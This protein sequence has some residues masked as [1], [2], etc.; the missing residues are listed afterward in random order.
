MADLSMKRLQEFQRRETVFQRDQRQFKTASNISLQSAAKRDKIYKICKQCFTDGPLTTHRVWY[1][2]KN[3]GNK[4]FASESDLGYEVLLANGCSSLR[5]AQ[6]TFE[7]QQRS[8]LEEQHFVEF[9]YTET[10]TEWQH[11]MA[12]EEN[13]EFV[14]QQSA[15]G[16]QISSPS[17]DVSP[18]R[19]EG[20]ETKRNKRSEVSPTKEEKTIIEGNK[21]PD[22]LRRG[23]FIDKTKLQMQPE[24]DSESTKDNTQF[25]DEKLDSDS[26]NSAM[27]DEL[28]FKQKIKLTKKGLIELPTHTNETSPSPKP[29]FHDESHNN[30]D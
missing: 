19:Y 27:I 3:E 10:F 12:I 2:L 29:R 11:L 21:T 4:G 28:F 24:S 23:A 26:Y 25:Y 15:S 20:T 8:Y 5:T 13:Q 1:K 7:L 9:D 30:S 6:K 16:S 14:L 18:T 17:K 22:L